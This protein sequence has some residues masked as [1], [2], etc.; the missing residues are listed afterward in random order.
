MVMTVN[1]MKNKNKNLKNNNIIFIIEIFGLSAAAVCLSVI[2]SVLFIDLIGV[3]CIIAAAAL[4]ACV[5]F[6]W[7]PSMIIISGIASFAI[8]FAMSGD[9]INALASLIYIIIG[10]LIYFGVRNKKNRTQITVG[11]TVVLVLFHIALIILSFLLS[12]G[13]FSIDM[14]SSAI[15]SELEQFTNFF[16]NFINSAPAQTESVAETTAQN[17]YLV[18]AYAQELVLNLKALIPSAFVLY[19]AFIAY[20]ATV[21]FKSAYNIFIPM[22]HPNRKK[23]KNKYWRLNISSV[24]AVITIAAIFFAVLF[25]KEILPSIVLTNLIYILAPGFCIVGLYFVYDK[26]FK[27]KSG[28]FPVML[29]VG[30]IIFAFMLPVVLFAAIILLMSVGLYATLI[31]DIKKFFEKA[32]KTL[33]GDGDDDDD[34]DYID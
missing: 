31:D 25:S 23:I 26:I 14:V 13:T 1:K 30:A 32:K 28:I 22:A 5:L 4:F 21:I 20:F 7:N 19:A 33:L 24:S 17:A 3:L 10:S 8:T 34:D 15:D 6:L 12:T 11:I 29:I 27:A 2:S 16:I 18:E 9:I